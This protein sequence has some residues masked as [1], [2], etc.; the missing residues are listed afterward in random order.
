MMLLTD[1]I[2]QILIA[3][4]LGV[5]IGIER[6]VAHKTAGMRTYGLLSMGSCL[7][8]IISEYI[9]SSGAIGASSTQITA[10][11]VTGLGFMCGGVIIFRDEHLSGLTT[12]AGLW[13][14]AGVGM[15]VGYGLIWLAVFTTFVTLFTFTFLWII[16]Q[17]LIG[18]SGRVRM[19]ERQE[20]DE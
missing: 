1:S 3:L 12:A 9:V 19:L 14:S 8:V 16:E 4:F 20:R 5:A 7:F 18:E 17:Y 11:I 2:W 13:V 6:S 15:A 10:G